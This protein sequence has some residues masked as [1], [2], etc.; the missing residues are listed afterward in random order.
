MSLITTLFWTSIGTA[1]PS[2]GV[3]SGKFRLLDVE[4]MDIE[5]LRYHHQYRDPYF[6]DQDH[7]YLQMRDGAALNFTLGIRDTI[8][9][10]NK[11]HMD[12]SQDTTV[13][14]KVGWEWEAGL[15]L[16]FIPIDVFQYHH[17]QHG[18]EYQNPDGEKFPVVDAYGA[19]IT[20]VG[21]K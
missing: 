15:H 6:V 1:E 3:A 20:L 14:K 12:N 18:M 16:P 8:Y 21:G 5:Y 17:S 13:P 7:Q 2:P 9:W 10:K 19:R 4:H 11:I